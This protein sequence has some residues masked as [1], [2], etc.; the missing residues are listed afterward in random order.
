M[1]YDLNYWNFQKSLGNNKY[2]RV[3][4]SSK[5]QSKIKS[6]EKVLDFGCGGGYVLDSLN[7]AY[8]CGVEVNDSAIKQ[9]LTYDIKVFK[10]TNEIQDAMFDVVISNSALE[11]VLEPLNVLKELYRI[12][13]KNGKLIIS[14]PHE[15]ISYSYESGD[16]NQHL[17]TWSPM[18]AGNLVDKAGFKVEEVIVSKII[19]PPL[20]NLI[21]GIFGLKGYKF[22]GGLYRIIRKL[23]IPIKRMGVTGD[24]IIHAKKQ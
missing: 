16:I 6:T 4:V 11:H 24:I 3:Y 15:D 14:V 21:Y 20:A 18:S 7:C 12:T 10:T 19:K 5:F 1:G 2:H 22:F 17:Y 23:L 9:A 13:K 8:K